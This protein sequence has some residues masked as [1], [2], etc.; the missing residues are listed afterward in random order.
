MSA[1]REKCDEGFKDRAGGVVQEIGGVILRTG[2]GASSAAQS[3]LRQACSTGAVGP[4]ATFDVTPTPA[5]SV[6]G[7]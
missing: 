5:G 1:H 7:R 2:R 3:P 4:A 6:G